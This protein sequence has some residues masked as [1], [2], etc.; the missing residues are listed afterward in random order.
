MNGE[1][2]N[3]DEFKIERCMFVDC[4]QAGIRIVNTQSVYGSINDCSL[5][6][7]GTG[8]ET[9]SHL[10]GYNL[11]FDACGPDFKISSTAH[12]RVFGWQSERSR[13]LADLSADAALFAD[14]GYIQIGAIAGGVM[15]NAFP[16][17]EAQIILRNMQ[18]TQNTLAPRPKIRFGASE[19]DVAVGSNFRVKILDCTG[20]YPDQFQLAGR[21]WAEVPESRG[22]VE[23]RGSADK[24]YHFHNFLRMKPVAAQTLD[25]SRIDL[26]LADTAPTN[27]NAAGPI[28]I[29]WTNAHVYAGSGSPENAIAASIGSIYLRTDGGTGST[30]Y[31]KESG[32]E[33]TGWVAK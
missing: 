24:A 17:N 20:L 8:I 22:E 28:G 3:N 33:K 25:T 10:T 31:V 5:S 12:V 13:K 11:C 14:G 23:F 6:E 2:G 21:L 4:A 19:K 7:C 26:A 1:N 16:S 32:T 29:Q 30:F 15:I 18:F 9:A 27:I